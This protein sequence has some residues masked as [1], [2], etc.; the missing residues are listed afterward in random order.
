MRLFFQ[1]IAAVA[2]TAGVTLA[3]PSQA[4][5]PQPADTNWAVCSFEVSEGTHV[6]QLLFEPFP[7]A[8]DKE[9][10]PSIREKF[11]DE[12]GVASVLPGYEAFTDATIGYSNIDRCAVF[13]SE[14]EAQGR[15]DSRRNARGY[16]FTKTVQWRPADEVT[17]LALA[18]PTTE[19][20][21][22]PAGAEE[23]SL[24][25]D[26]SARR[27]AE[28]Q[29]RREVEE[30]ARLNRGMADFVARQDAENRAAQ[31]KADADR[32]AYEE[33]LAKTEREREAYERAM[34]QNRRDREE[35]ARA[36]QEFLAA[37]Q[38]HA[39]CLGGDRTA[40]ADIEAGRP[41]LANADKPQDAS[42]DTDA[43]RCVSSPVVSPD[44]AF[45]GSI[46]AVVTNGCEA[47]VDVRICLLRTGGWNCAV[48]W[49]LAR[50]ASWTHTSFESDGQVFWD[51][52]VSTS[53]RPLARP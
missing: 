29:E 48:T 45:R 35:S 49:N 9:T 20:D 53:S 28:E 22:D 42:T 36:A 8:A 47:A 39:R 31:R 6:G 15:F 2:T 12:V 11:E 18:A 23:A 50:Q 34:E 32:K 51:A 33:A 19:P 44:P 38:R 52:R 14:E 27:E 41:A 5:A 40:C 3:A 30:T 26:D 1:R 43:T 13:A 17:G 10:F 4:Q 21:K 37:Q 16:R 7:I 46:Q 24:A 25:V